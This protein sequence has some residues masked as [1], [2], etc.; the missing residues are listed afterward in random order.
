MTTAAKEE[1][2]APGLRFME[3]YSRGLSGHV[4]VPP[5]FDV[6]G[7][8]ALST[9]ARSGA[10][11]RALRFFDDVLIDDVAVLVDLLELESVR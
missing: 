8:D 2:W 5:C 11:G 1:V 6:N 7:R 3:L 9:P 10:A 4:K